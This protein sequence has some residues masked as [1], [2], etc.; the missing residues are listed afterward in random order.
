MAE[1]DAPTSK[2]IKEMTDGVAPPPTVQSR[3]CEVYFILPEA[4][5]T[6]RCD[7]VSKRQTGVGRSRT[8][9][10]SRGSSRH[11]L[12]VLSLLPPPRALRYSRRL[13]VCVS[14][15]GWSQPAG[16]SLAPLL[17]FARCPLVVP[18]CRYRPSKAMIR[19]LGVPF[20][21]RAA[22]SFPLALRLL[23]HPT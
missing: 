2:Y 3:L 12:F 22:S 7:I 18:L 4:F 8:A 10:N 14:A 1:P 15:R 6:A 16:P 23:N 21:S 20:P 13:R 11:P 17:H 5:V 9:F 19:S